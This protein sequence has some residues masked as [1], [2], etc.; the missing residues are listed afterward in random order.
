MPVLGHTVDFYRDQDGLLRRGYN[1]HGSLFSITLMSQPFAVL[2]GAEHHD[3]FFKQTDKVL[4]MEKPYGFLAAM[5]GKIAFL[6]THEQY[7][8]HR[9]VLHSLMGR[10]Q[11]LSHLVVMSRV[12]NDWIAGL[13][14]SGEMEI[15]AEMGKLV[16]EV[17]GRCFLGDAVHERLQAAGFWDQYDVLSASLDPLLYKL[18]LPKFIRRDQ[19]KKRIRAILQP[20]ID[21]RRRQPVADGF[22][23]LLDQ[24]DAS[25]Q[26]L[27]DEIVANF[28]AALMFAGHETTAGQA[29]WSLIQL[30]REPQVLSQVRAE[31][32]TV[33]ADAN[34]V[35]HVHMRNL[36]LVAAAVQETG[37]MR[38][39]AETLIRAV[40]EDFEL[41]GY[42]IPKGWFVMTSTAASH[43]LP[44]VFKDPYVYNPNRFLEGGEGK[45]FNYI[46]FGGGLHKCTGVNFAS[47]EMAIIMALLFRSYDLELVTP[48]E[49]IGVERT[50]S[51][52][53]QKAV[54]RYKRRAAT[55]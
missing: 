38:P 20:I 1:E 27:P 12:V 11:M 31:V 2:I 44:D 9:P 37:R 50:G 40:K 13:G 32:D 28:F 23:H 15:T 17:A 33:L 54:V 7:L 52:K 10:E 18:P 43:F 34:A 39:S 25:G 14:D 36:R 16:K 4:D 22:Q 26:P 35:D 41:S 51:S 5:F 45:G 3:F 30:S 21:E 49:N 42:R 53:P 29:A 19:A 48:Y 6:G 24:P 8:L 47:T 46:A 55:R